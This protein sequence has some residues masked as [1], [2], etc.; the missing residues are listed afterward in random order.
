M[1]K[2]YYQKDQPKDPIGWIQGLNAS[3]YAGCLRNGNIVDRREFPEA[4]PIQGNS[5]FGVVKPKK[6][7]DET[8]N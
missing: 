1:S 6:L 5:M 2:V 8:S 7:C 3:G 4:I